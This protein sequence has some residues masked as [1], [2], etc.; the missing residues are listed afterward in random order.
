[1]EP[2]LQELI[3]KLETWIEETRQVFL[4]DLMELARAMGNIPTA[5]R[6][7]AF[8]KRAGRSPAGGASPRITMQ[9]T[10]PQ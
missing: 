6:A 2:L 3:P 1:M 8:W 4:D 5:R 10:A 7:P 9:T